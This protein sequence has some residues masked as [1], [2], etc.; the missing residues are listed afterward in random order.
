MPS[1]PSD[2]PIRLAQPADLSA[3]QDHR[4]TVNP[5][6]NIGQAIGVVV[7]GMGR[8]GTSSVTRMFANAG[9]FVGSDDELM[10]ATEANATGHWENLRIWRL[11]EQLLEQ[12][13][14]SW[15][16][17]PSVEEQMAARERATRLF[18][19]EIERLAN[20]AQGM[21][22]ALKDPRIGVM[23]PL[24]GPMLHR[25]FR[26]VLVVRDPCEIAQSLHR[27]DGTPLAFAIGAWEVHMALLLS[28]FANRH[29]MVLPYPSIMED[30]Q[31]CHSAIQ[32]VISQ[33]DPSL[34]GALRPELGFEAFQP[35]L[36]HNRA[37]AENDVE[38]L[39]GR[40]LELWRYLS[41]LGAGEQALDP[42]EDLLRPST[43]ALAAVGNETERLQSHATQAQLKSELDDERDR[44]M[45]LTLMLERERAEHVHD[46]RERDADARAE[47]QQR[48][49]DILLGQERIAELHGEITARDS[50][51]AQ[52]EVELAAALHLN[53]RTEESITWQTFQRIRG[54]LY[55]A[56]GEHSLLAQAL[57]LFLKGA[58]MLLA[59]RRNASGV[60]QAGDDSG[61][62][63]PAGGPT[64]SLPEYDDPTVSLIIPLYAHA[65]LTRACLTSIREHTS[66]VSYEVILVDDDADEETKRLLEVVH[67]AKIV[68][69]E[70]N[71]GYLRSVNHGASKAHGRWLVLFN[72]DTEVTR[73]WLRA[74]LACAE[75][76]DDIGVVT[77]K[78]IYPNGSLNEAGGL[79]WRDGTGMNYGRGE[80]PNNFQYEYRREVDYGSAAALM[81]DAE[82][83]RQVGGYDERYLPMF[84]EDADLCFQ[85]RE[86]GLR[87]M[88]EPEAV[89]VHIEGATTGNDVK[90]GHKRHQ[91]ENRPRF[92]T[93]W[94]RQLESEHLRPG[95]T[96]VWAA[97]NHHKG[98]HVLVVDHRVPMW[99]RDAG[100][101]RMLN[102]MHAL[103]RLG[104]R[105]TFMPDSF[106]RVEPYTRA[107]Q[108][109][110]IEVLYGELHLNAVMA[111]IGPR[112]DLAILSRPHAASR[113]LDTI[114]EAAP[115]AKLVYDTVDLHWLREARRAGMGSSGQSLDN[116]T[117]D[118]IA[119]KAQAL[120][121]LELAMM[122][123]SDAVIVVSECEREQVEK[124]A[125]GQ[126]VLVIPTV[127]DVEPFVPPPEDRTG[128]IFVG[129]FEHP[130]NVDA[131]VRLVREVMPD[132]WRSL[133]DVRVTIVGPAPPPEVERLASARVDVTGWVE[134]LRPLLEQSRLMLAPLR[135][136]AGV[137]GKITQALASGLPVVTTPI[138][139]EGIEGQFA[140]V[141]E[142]P[143]E[144]AAHTVQLYRDDQLWRD[145]SH[146]GQ[147]L[148]AQQFSTE[149]V[150]K[151][152]GELLERKPR[153]T[154]ATAS[155]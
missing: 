69:N 63:R 23:L 18:D 113:W 103:V 130:P 5:D 98:P 6:S 29:V 3:G 140:L 78:F 19:A 38:R 144:L 135:Y 1:E 39:T 153:L 14:A 95:P 108:R 43:A 138:G 9:F 54:R 31:M 120:R 50:Q 60:A 104:A 122:R 24:W 37:S 70:Q 87:V 86:H 143:A 149:V 45:Q 125:P 46:S 8:S 114:R 131:A 97:A 26:P 57:Q 139:I 116:G 2:T 11:N 82:L 88:Y 112:L 66:H 83:W 64:I 148:V 90:S 59:K 51:L 73:G 44:G 36:R 94:R 16:D 22:I 77:P 75:S 96:N 127:H 10:P 146:A 115:S 49:R 74:M 141:G 145:L 92:V 136:G 134:D 107:L 28:E 137:K 105:V 155:S 111:T 132:V 30:E 79:I 4:D 21:P 40:Q 25:R 123:A 109:M 118:D 99:D 15:F 142:D 41:S 154:S 84:Y 93:K 47:I 80:Q 58:G 76:A 65:E 147:A 85:A 35:A 52:R 72:N 27:R 13:G 128:I 33:L 101:L 129:G 119:P 89:V 12:F 67:G 53:R 106:A 61:A 20:K 48:D 100:S 150:Y 42:P 32:S 117:T 17:P 55:H 151:R 102:V 152:L 71:I 56:I 81:V 91:E 124:D 133:G 34:T 126:E 110:G 7:L 68:R 121:H 62:A